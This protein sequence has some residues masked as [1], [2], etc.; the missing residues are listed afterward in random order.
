MCV[1][2]VSPYPR[3]RIDGV[4]ENT[5]HCPR[6]AVTSEHSELIALLLHYRAGYLFSAGG[7][8]DQPAKY[9]A[10]MRLMDSTARE[11]EYG[12]K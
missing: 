12:S 9:L 2:G 6:R 7:L 5:R 4:L 10:A 8:E 1:D 11:I 3:W